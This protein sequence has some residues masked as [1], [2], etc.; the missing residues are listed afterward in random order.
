MAQ[1]LGLDCFLKNPLQLF[2]H[3]SST[4]LALCNLATD[5]AVKQS[6]MVLIVA[7]TMMVVAALAY[8]VW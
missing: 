3:L 8:L 5:I 2:I 4:C 1:H 7:V 6:I